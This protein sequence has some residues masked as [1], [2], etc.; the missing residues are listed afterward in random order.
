MRKMYGDPP[1]EQTENMGE[2]AE[3]TMVTRSRKTSASSTPISIVITS[4]QRDR[5]A[6]QS[7]V[8]RL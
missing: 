6:A 2:M 8:T 7:R 1:T 5:N 3:K 4:N